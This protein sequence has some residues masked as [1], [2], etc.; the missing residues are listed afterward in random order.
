MMVADT[1]IT[2][3]KIICKIKY[4]LCA[5]MYGVLEDTWKSIKENG[6]EVIGYWI[7]K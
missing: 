7:K 5:I 3:Q 4:H 2:K 6:N 1:I